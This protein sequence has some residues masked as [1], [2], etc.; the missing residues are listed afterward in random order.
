VTRRVSIFGA[1]GSIGC[2]TVDLIQREPERFE[3]VALT[4]GRNIALLAEQARALRADLAVT[5]HPECFAD[6]KAALDGSGIEVAAGPEAII[7]AAR[8]PADWVMSAIV[9][10]AGLPPGLAALEE[11]ATLALANKESLVTAGPLLLSTA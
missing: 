2:N 9:G 10:A 7:D 6:L 3:V 5:A 8:R 11:G 4:G 1:T